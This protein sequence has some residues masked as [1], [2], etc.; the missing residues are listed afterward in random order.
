MRIRTKDQV[1]G[2]T[3]DGRV[4]S[5]G[6]GAV[7]DVDDDD[8]GMVALFKDFVARGV[9]EIVEEKKAAKASD[10]S[11]DTEQSED[12]PVAEAEVEPGPVTHTRYED[13]TIVELRTLARARNLAV[14]GSK[15][16]LV[17]RLRGESE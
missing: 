5:A 9:A 3:S 7:T 10:T 11:A 16:D 2:R 12:G 17:A 15:D 1:N 4:Y 14:S 8:E 13:R 6:E